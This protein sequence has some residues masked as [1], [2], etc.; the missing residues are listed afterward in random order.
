M[1]NNTQDAAYSTQD[2]G[3]GAIDRSDHT[4]AHP[5]SPEPPHRDIQ[6]R[7]GPAICLALV[8]W[9]PVSSYSGPRKPQPHK[10]APARVC[11]LSGGALKG[12]HCAVRPNKPRPHG[13]DWPYI[14]TAVCV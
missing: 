2:P 11:G 8:A 3:E 4:H 1:E 14:K 6:T 13:P 7:P 5:Q 10:I 9:V 12:P